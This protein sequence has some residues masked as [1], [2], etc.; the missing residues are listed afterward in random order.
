M[1][2]I[3][4]SIIVN[5]PIHKVWEAIKDPQI[6]MQWHPFVTHIGGE[7][8]HGAIRQC[9]AEV[10]GKA[11]YTEERCSLY[12]EDH[13]IMWEIQ[14]DSTGFSDMVTDWA[15]GFTL[16]DNNGQ[17]TLVIAQ[18]FFRPKKFF[19]HLMMP[20]IRYKFHQVQ[21]QI[22]GGLKHYAEIH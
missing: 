3:Q 21:K 22:L 12:E 20:M 14:K 18:S 2:S 5:A 19:V 15:A 13:K 16:Q 1:K 6:H 10:G 8:A 17:T 4:D 9:S 11:G 7:H